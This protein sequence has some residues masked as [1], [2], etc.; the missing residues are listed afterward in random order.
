MCLSDT[1]SVWKPPH[2]IAAIM[3]DLSA[4][5]G[6]GT[7]LAALR[8]SA[9]SANTQTETG[10][11]PRLL[12]AVAQ[13]SVP[14]AHEVCEPIVQP[15]EMAARCPLGAAKR[16]KIAI[17]RA[18][19]GVLRSAVD[20]A[21]LLAGRSVSA[22]RGAR[23]HGHTCLPSSS[24]ISARLPVSARTIRSNPCRADREVAARRGAATRTRPYSLSC[25][26]LP[27][28]EPPQL[29]RCPVCNSAVE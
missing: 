12:C 6:R 3:T 17:S 20:H 10:H 9:L 7:P 13:L 24:E 4:A 25:P 19:G 28:S 21:D 18:D 14:A 5:T 11:L 23:R 29:Y 27:C 2:A 8:L 1:A 26:N 15:D 22:K 16:D